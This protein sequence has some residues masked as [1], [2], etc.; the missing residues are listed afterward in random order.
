MSESQK[1]SPPERLEKI[2]KDADAFFSAA[3]SSIDRS[4]SYGESESDA[5]WN[6]L[7]DALRDVGSGIINE[8]ISFASDMAIAIRRSPFLGEEDERQAGLAL[9][10][11]RA[12]IRLRRYRF[13]DSEVLHDEGT[14]IGMRRAEQDDSEPN[15]PMLSRRQ[16]NDGAEKLRPIVEFSIDGK[17]L[18]HH[19]LSKL[20]SST[21][22]RPGTAFIMMWISKDIPELIDVVDTI[23]RCCNKFSIIA[24]R[25]DDI[26]HSD[27]ITA[28]IVE[29]IRT[30]EFLI[31]DL[32]GERPSVYYEIGFAHAIDKRVIL[33]RK[34]GTPIHFDLAAYNCPE[35][36][37][38]KELESLLTKR[39]TA[40]TGREP[41]P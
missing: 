13:W 31:A 40:L 34:A 9:K 15:P 21:G 36:N 32:S 18:D 17:E 39:L 28:K 37:N 12:A 1:L 5:F 6:Q 10:T 35:Y 8:I 7:P 24:L 41:K 29:E 16:F 4:I 22:Y 27:V 19:P 38:M 25:A 11:M 33:Y 30:S 2:I 23:K 3:E 20:T 26:E 14:Y